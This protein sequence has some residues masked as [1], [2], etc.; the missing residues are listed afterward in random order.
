MKDDR[1]VIGFEGFGFRAQLGAFGLHFPQTIKHS[2]SS[3]AFD[4]QVDE[5]L[6]L[7]V[8]I[9][10][11]IGD[12][13]QLAGL[14]RRK[15]AALQVVVRNVGGDHLGIGQ[16]GI[17]GVEHTLFDMRP[18]DR[19]TIFAITALAIAGAADA[20]IADDGIACA[21]AAAFRKAG[22]EMTGLGRDWP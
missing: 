19:A 13:L 7:L 2:V 15:L 16:V 17:E 14:S 6:D 21:A 8:E 3:T 9:G 1:F 18:R 10:Q 22:K 12:G 11:A 5:F 4:K 20:I